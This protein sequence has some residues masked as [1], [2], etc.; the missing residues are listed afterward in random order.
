MTQRYD[1]KRMQD[2]WNTM[3]DG[4][5]VFFVRNPALGLWAHRGRLEGD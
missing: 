5:R 2:G 4:E 3:S 1:P